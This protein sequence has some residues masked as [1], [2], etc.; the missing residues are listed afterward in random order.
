MIKQQFLGSF[1]ELGLSILT[2]SSSS[3]DGSALEGRGS[4]IED[5][6]GLGPQVQKLANPAK[7]SKQMR[8]PYHLSLLVPHRLHELHHPYTGI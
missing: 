4:T 7:E 6:D 2:H 8:V 3:N 1:S 5:K